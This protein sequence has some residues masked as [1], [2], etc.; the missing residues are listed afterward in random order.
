MV[1]IKLYE[2]HAVRQLRQDVRDSLVLSGELCLL[3]QMYHPGYAGIAQ[4]PNCTD[5]I[6]VSGEGDCTVCY[7]TSWVNATGV[8]SGVMGVAKVYGLFSDTQV[9]EELKAKGTYIPDK[10]EIQTEAFP[11]LVEHDIVVRFRNWDTDGLPTELEGFYGIQ[12]VT[13]TS[14]R[15][16]TRGGQYSW[17]VV[18]QRA[19]VTRLDDALPIY[20]FPVLGE[21]FAG[22]VVPTTPYVT[23]I[24]AAATPAANRQTPLV[25]QHAVP[26]TVWTINH[27]FDYPPKVTVII[28]SE[29]VDADVR[30]F[31]GYVTVTF[32]D[33]QAGIAVV[34]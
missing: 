29:E 26:E 15:T 7:G 14:L 25:H 12:T 3:M 11:M 27:T 16:G 22:A 13:R 19:V 30:Y 6:Y 20:Q 8:P 24:P 17:D 34:S 5:D 18:G 21:A 10:R 1:S 9:P 31:A 32:E 33:P 28:N 4:C 23:A 2:N